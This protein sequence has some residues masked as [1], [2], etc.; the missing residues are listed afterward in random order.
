MSTTEYNE[1]RAE[2]FAGRLLDVLNGGALAVMIS[3]GHRTGLFDALARMDAATS[4]ELAAAA[5]KNER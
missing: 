2:E 4:E 3:V 5:G 1:A